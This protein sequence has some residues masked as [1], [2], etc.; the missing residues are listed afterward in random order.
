M[1]KD[2]GM[3]PDGEE[4]I[5]RSIEFYSSM[6]SV[7]EGWT[8]TCDG[9]DVPEW[10]SIEL[11]DG[12]DEEGNFSGMVN[13]EVVAEPLPEGVTYREAIVRFEFPGAYLDYK[14]MQ[15]KKPDFNIFDVN[16][17]G[18]VN[19]ADVNALLAMI[20]DNEFDAAGDVNQDG[21]VNIA[22]VN[23]VSDYILTH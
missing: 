9:D 3:G 21:E 12:E 4:V 14:F 6:P 23:A 19:I 10:L 22:D 11:T 16:R 18:E 20:L 7:D 1:E 5:T 15:G 8:L 13:A 2:L 17:D